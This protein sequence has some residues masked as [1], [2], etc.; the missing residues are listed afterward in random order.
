MFNSVISYQGVDQGCH[1]GG[2]FW[3]FAEKGAKES[4]F[5]IPDEKKN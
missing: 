2:R 5:K 4:V 3:V 1:F